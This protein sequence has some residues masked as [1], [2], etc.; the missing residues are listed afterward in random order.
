MRHRFS[1]FLLLNPFVLTPFVLISFA[2]PS[3]AQDS[4]PWRLIES[5]DNTRVAFTHQLRFENLDGQFRAGRLG[6]S[7]QVLL[8]RTTVTGEYRHESTS[9]VIEA[10]DARQALADS[11]SSLTSKVVNTAN[12]QQLYA[13]AKF[14]DFLQGTSTLDLKLGRQTIDLGSRRV[15]A[16]STFSTVPTSFDGLHSA[17]T[18]EDGSRLQL[19][20]L[21][22]VPGIPN[23]LNDLLANRTVRDHRSD[24]IELWGAFSELPALTEWLRGDFYY[25]RLN[26]KDTR[27]QAGTNRQLNHYGVRLFHPAAAEQM[28][29]DVETV[30]QRGSSHA[31]AA[32]TDVRALDHDAYFLHAEVGYSF[33][34]TW[35]PRVQALFDYASGDENP[36]DGSMER[37]G[38]VYGERRFDFGPTS[39]YGPFAR[40]NLVSAGYRINAT[41][42]AGMRLMVTHREFRLAESRDT[43]S[44]TGLRDSLGRAG[45]GL[46]QQLEARLQ[47]DV[48]P[49]NLTLESGFAWVN[50]SD[51]AE[52][53]GG[54]KMP[55]QTHYAYLQSQLT[56]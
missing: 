24:A 44:G 53:V 51:F 47:W 9:V 49:G 36:L 42:A 35:N 13:T 25:I 33:A 21:Q 18:L 41:P 4:Q 56:F 50:W 43:W 54:A 46:G 14:S 40:T 22:P 11:G 3:F 39:L 32:S 45:R 23:N 15:I 52:R 16:R 34:A 1:A 10:L 5:T 27:S 7:D 38:D 37:I 8:S 28:D 17:L 26:E 55:S 30:L 19:F 29:F 6:S 12:L 20:Y 31:T 48:M 2:V